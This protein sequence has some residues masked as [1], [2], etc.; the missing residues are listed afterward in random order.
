MIVRQFISWIRTAPAGE[1]AE[2]T[3]SLARAWLV[4]DLTGEDRAAAEGALLMMLDD[5]SPLVRQAM[6]EVFARSAQAP[7]AIV[8]ALSLDQP[9]VALPVLEHS[10]LLIDADLV[11]IVATGNCETQC[12]IARRVHLPASVCAAIAEVGT[13]AA[14]LELIENAYAALAPFSWDRIVERHGHLAAIRESMLVLDGLPAATRAALVAKLSDT[15]AQ[16]VVAR[17]W[18]SADRAGRVASEARD[19]STVNIAAISRGDDMRGLVRHLRASGQLTAGLIL[20]A[21]LSGNLEL[22]DSA[23]AELSGLP[24]ARVSALLGDH[25]SASL[26]ALLRRAGL[27]ELTFAAFQIALEASHETGFAD[28]AGSATRLRRRMVERVLT[29]CETDR[30]AAEPLLILLRRFATELAR[31]EARMFCDEL[32]ADEAIAPIEHGLIAA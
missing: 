17:N 8:Q 21:L 25:G 20:R 18:L 1:R 32:V 24:R 28:T 23:L 5:A 29:H 19:R 26:H 4:S 9:S 6:A 3:R 14:A 22:F 30:Q 7:A 12:A 10:P 27:P 11:D 16:F 15:L 31:E 2:A 13:P